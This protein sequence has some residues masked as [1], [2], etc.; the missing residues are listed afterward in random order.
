[1]TK[2]IDAHL[3]A[4]LRLIR[5]RHGMTQTELGRAAGLSFQ[6]VQKYE[7]GSN[8]IAA[9]T[10]YIFAKALDTPVGDFFPPPDAQH[11][12]DTKK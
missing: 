6:Q 2:P 12:Q 5:K 7:S 11:P 1:M 10:L 4:T 3:G 8:R 9:S